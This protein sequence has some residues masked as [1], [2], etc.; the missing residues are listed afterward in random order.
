MDYMQ[1]MFLF[2]DVDGVLNKSSDWAVPY[3]LNPDCLSIFKECFGGMDIKI[4]LVTSWRK[5]FISPGNPGNTPQI[6]K[7]EQV[8]SAMGVRVC[9]TVSHTEPD[10]LKSIQDFLEAHPGKYIILDDDLREYDGKHPT[11]LYLVNNKTGL[12]KKDI[13]LIRKMLSIYT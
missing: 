4:I 10:R 12:C 8:M 2:L 6:K 5:G 9:G 1:N 3:T 13:R 7:L 11:G